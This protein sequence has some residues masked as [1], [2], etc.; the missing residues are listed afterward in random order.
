[1]GHDDDKYLTLD[2]LLLWMRCRHLRREATEALNRLIEV[3]ETQNNE[4]LYSTVLKFQLP[5]AAGYS[6]CQAFKSHS[7]I[8]DYVLQSARRQVTMYMSCLSSDTSLWSDIVG[9]Q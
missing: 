3:L 2:E 9:I 6:A 7:Y 4:H 1:M 8:N 5:E